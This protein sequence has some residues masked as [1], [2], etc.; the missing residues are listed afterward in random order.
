MIRSV[1]CLSAFTILASFSQ[2]YILIDDFTVG[3][4][5]KT[6]T[7]TG[8]DFHIAE[9]LDKSHTAWGDR[10]TW[11]FVHNN[12]LHREVTLNVGSGELSVSTLPGLADGL[13]TQLDTEY[14]RGASPTTVD[15]SMETEF[16]IDLNVKNPNGR[17]ADLW[18]MYA[19]DSKGVT[20][21]ND[22]WLSRQGG[23]RFRKSGFVGNP[24]WSSIQY[25]EF[26]QRF[27]SPGYPEAYT[28]TKIYTLPEPTSASVAA[29][30]FLTLRRRA[31]KVDR[32]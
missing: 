29:L 17:F 19:R 2:A 15:F 8:S 16:W 26:S 12:P 3:D 10:Q 13:H 20:G 1:A 28:V 30:A 14:G 32:Q 22:G 4:Y 6:F 25:L 7:T 24:D 27:S 21:T 5:S 23:L 11:F 9:G 31:R 18:T